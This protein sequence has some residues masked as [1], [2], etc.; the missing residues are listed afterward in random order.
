M[1]LGDISVPLTVIQIVYLNNK[2]R[3]FLVRIL[4]RKYNT[5]NKVFKKEFYNKK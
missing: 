4:I 3:S 1:F 2:I 5:D